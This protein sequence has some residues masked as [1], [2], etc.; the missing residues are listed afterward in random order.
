LYL[1][2]ARRHTEINDK[3][4]QKC[5][6]LDPSL[7]PAVTLTNKNQQPLASHHSIGWF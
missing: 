6:S 1:W 7:C 5:R 4:D 3:I 2:N